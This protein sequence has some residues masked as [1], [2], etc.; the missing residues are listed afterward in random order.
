MLDDEQNIVKHDH[1]TKNKLDD[2]DFD[3]KSKNSFKPHLSKREQPSSQVHKNVKNGPSSSGFALVVPV[4]L[5]EIFKG[6]DGKFKV[7][8]KA[9]FP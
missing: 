7:A 1:D 5:G 8:Q 4:H 9:D 6:G 2:V 3:V